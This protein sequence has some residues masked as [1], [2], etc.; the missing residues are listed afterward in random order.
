MPVFKTAWGPYWFGCFECN[1]AGEYRQRKHVAERDEDEHECVGMNQ[2][3]EA[4]AFVM[5]LRQ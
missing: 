2:K 5:E 3:R 1:F 4:L